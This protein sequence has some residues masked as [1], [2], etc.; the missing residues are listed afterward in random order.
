MQD[1]KQT[2]Q[3][4]Q[5]N[6]LMQPQQGMGNR[7]QVL[8]QSN[9]QKFKTQLCRHFKNGNCQLASSCQFAHGQQELR[10]N[11][12]QQNFQRN[13]KQNMGN[14]K[15]ARCK[16]FDQGFC[17]NQQNC[18]F[19]HGDAELNQGN[20]YN[21]MMMQNQMFYNPQQ[22]MMM[23]G[24][25]PYMQQQYFQNMMYNQQNPQPFQQN[26]QNQMQ[27][28]GNQQQSKEQLNEQK[29]LAMLI[30]GLFQVFNGNQAAIQQLQKIQEHNNNFNQKQVTEEL[31]NLIKDPSRTQAEL[32]Q[33][34][35]LYKEAQQF[36]EQLKQQSQ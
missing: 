10:G 24:Q 34:Q 16:H 30:E 4:G 14:Y 15:T 21:N 11:L 33:Y 28:Q 23:Y 18:T 8:G 12:P 27:G 2:P 17:K 22:M 6:M 31:Q 32:D 35:Q 13:Q 20:N 25:N 26:Q 5:Q 19:A 1:N 3:Q 7:P 29:V 9:V 36:S